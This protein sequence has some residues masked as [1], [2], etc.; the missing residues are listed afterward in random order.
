MTYFIIVVIL[1]AAAAA[2]A[3]AAY[4]VIAN[5]AHMIGCYVSVI[6]NFYLR[7]SS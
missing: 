3:A 7:R 6:I 4:G 2:A 1:S 5:V